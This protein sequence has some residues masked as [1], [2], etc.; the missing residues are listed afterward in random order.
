[1]PA[2]ARKRRSRVRGPT[3]ARWR[4]DRCRRR[5]RR[6]SA[7]GRRP[8]R[9]TAR[10]GPRANTRRRRGSRRSPSSRRCRSPA[11]AA[12]RY[13]PSG[14]RTA[15]VR[16][17][18]GDRRGVVEGRQFEPSGIDLRGVERRDVEQFGGGG[19]CCA[20]RRQLRAVAGGGGA[21]GRPAS[22]ST[23]SGRPLIRSEKEATCTSFAPAARSI[24]R[25]Q[26]PSRILG[27]N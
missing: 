11:P 20:G 22:A 18:G 16:Q 21:A 6:S 8:C 25:P 12:R 13:R 4:R 24:R 9:R 17:F 19:R 7:G 5:G 23:R 14:Y 10:P 3:R 1:M 26:S 15:P 27:A 2:S